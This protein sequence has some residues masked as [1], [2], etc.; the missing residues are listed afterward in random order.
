MAFLDREHGL[1]YL[2]LLDKVWAARK[3]LE[4]NRMTEQ[5]QDFWDA[6][7]HFKAIGI[8]RRWDEM[9]DAL[10][11]LFDSYFAVQRSRE[12]SKAKEWLQ[13]EGVI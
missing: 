5:E 6:A 7:Q 1:E 13:S 11:T 2:G 3:W 10:K 9:D 8:G 12:P 4:D